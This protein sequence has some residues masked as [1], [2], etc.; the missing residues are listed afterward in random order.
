MDWHAVLQRCAITIPV[1]TA[2]LFASPYTYKTIVKTG[3]SFEGKI[4]SS[5]NGVSLNNPGTVAFQIGFTDGDRGIATQHGLVLHES[6][7]LT[8]DGFSQPFINDAGTVVFEAAYPKGAT[9]SK[10][11]M[12]VD[13]DLFAGDE[14][15]LGG[16]TLIR[17]WPIGIDN[18]GNILLSAS[19][20]DAGDYSYGFFTT[21]DGLVVKPG[22]T[23]DGYT[24]TDIGSPV[25]DSEG[26]IAFLA[27]YTT[28]SGDKG[29]GLFTPNHFL[30]STGQVIDGVTL[31][32][33]STAVVSSS[34]FYFMG[35][36]PAPGTPSPDGIFTPTSLLV[37]GN[38][39]LADVNDAG[40]LLFWGQQGLSTQYGP[41]APPGTMIDGLEM[42]G[43]FGQSAINNRGEVA[44]G[45]YL[46]N[47]DYAIVLAQPTQTP[48]P[49]T[50]LLLA[51]PALALLVLNRRK[52]LHNHI[53]T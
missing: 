34:G 32:Y 40:T 13:G 18:S 46:S 41:V 29:A 24:L 3:D 35:Y 44:F 4:V 1:I 11:A 17:P 28:A 12:F 30:V 25:I 47:G 5:L 43:P 45:A 37:R 14:I 48:E 19:F 2:T 10:Y 42:V 38:V 33:L 51:P 39:F 21:R 53:P 31:A 26:T 20:G 52:L 6:A 22:D 49:S 36:G 16:R 8:F 7:S 15:S 27:G 9:F 23:I 50:V